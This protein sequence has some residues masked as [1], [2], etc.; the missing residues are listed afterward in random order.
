MNAAAP[1]AVLWLLRHGKAVDPIG[2]PGGD[3][4]RPLKPRGEAQAESAGRTLAALAPDI[5]AVLTSPRVRARTTAELA[6]AAHGGAPEP[7]V[8]D[9]LGGDY[10]LGDLLALVSPWTEVPGA[11]VVVVGHNPTL[12]I[13][14]YDLTGDDRGL[15]TGALVGIDLAERRLLH[16]VRPEV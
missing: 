14:T 9:Q 2:F 4:A 16:H 8:F 1:G 13:L 6:V 3:A 15:S 11:G 5:A 10:N 7:I 12:S